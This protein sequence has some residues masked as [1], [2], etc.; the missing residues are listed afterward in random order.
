ME[1]GKALETVLAMATRLYKG[2]GE[3]CRPA[4]NP[5]EAEDALAT[6]EDLIVNNFG[7]D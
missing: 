5:A 6:V 1:T 3:L 4:K 7:E 2:Y